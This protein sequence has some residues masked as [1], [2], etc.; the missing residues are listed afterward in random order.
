MRKSAIVLFCLMCLQTRA[1][2]VTYSIN[3]N[4]NCTDTVRPFSSNTHSFGISIDG[5]GQLLSDSAFIRVVLVDSN[6]HEWLVYERNS[7]YATEE[8]NQF[9]GIATGTYTMR[10]ALED[11]TVFTDKV[12]KD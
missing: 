7:L 11:G 5:E 1:Q 3:R 12:V 9:Q 2:I 10:V 4:I 6:D 8:S